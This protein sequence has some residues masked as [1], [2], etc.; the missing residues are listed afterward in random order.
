MTRR[1][2]GSSNIEVSAIGLGCMGMSQS[3]GP[4][5]DQESIKTLHRALDLG[6]NFLDTAAIYGN[7]ANERLL[8]RVI[9]NR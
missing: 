9:P 4:G 3:Y 5:D 2:L 1:T 7:G 6:V 8:G